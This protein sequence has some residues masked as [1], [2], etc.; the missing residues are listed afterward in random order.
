MMV[1]SREGN[2]R[3]FT[4]VELLIFFVL[5]SL[6]AASLY[7]VVRFQQRAY[8]QQ[9]ETVARHDALRLASA[10]LIGDI[11][12]ASGGEGDFGAIAGDR[13]AVRSPTG[14][15]IICAHDPSDR[16]IALTD[17]TGIVGA[18]AGD[19]LLVYHPD[20][21]LVRAIQ[22]VNPQSASSLTCP[23][24]GGEAPE[25]T[26]RLTG[27]VSDVPVGAP[28]RGFRRYVY[29]LEQVDN[30]WWLVRDDG[31]TAWPLAGPFAGDSGLALTYFDS[32]G[33]A[34]TDPARVALVDLAIVA[35]TAVSGKRD[36]LAVSVRPRN[37]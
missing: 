33:Q 1:K 31:S 6:I 22:D 10:V 21:W 11:A 36:T 37:Q 30:A 2:S 29:R 5:A 28:V 32:I 34:T 3:G 9:N 13:I 19:S 23:Y 35:E 8:R 18:S 12:E 7:Q 26:L 17:V 27:S 25:M 14:F 15:G 4:L 16:R 24:D 20:G